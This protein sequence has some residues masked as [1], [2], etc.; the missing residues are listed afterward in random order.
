MPKI[1]PISVIPALNFWATYSD[2][3][4]NI[5]AAPRRSMNVEITRTLKDLGKAKY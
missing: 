3:K 5:N 1:R 4:G 2:R